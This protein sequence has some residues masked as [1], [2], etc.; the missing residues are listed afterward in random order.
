VESFPPLKLK[1][2]FSALI[3][4]MKSIYWNWFETDLLKLICWNC[5]DSWL[6]KLTSILLLPSEATIL[7]FSLYPRHQDSLSKAEDR[8][9]QTLEIAE[10]S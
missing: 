5:L 3:I 10:S 9:I 6:I 8:W 2:S 7:L 1:D 4:I